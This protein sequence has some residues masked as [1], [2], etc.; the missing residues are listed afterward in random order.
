L[1]SSEP[2]SA[3]RFLPEATALE[4]CALPQLDPSARPTTVARVSST[5]LLVRLVVKREECPLHEPILTEAAELGTPDYPNALRV[6]LHGQRLHP[7][8]LPKRLATGTPG[9]A[10]REQD[11]LAEYAQWWN[12]GLQDGTGF[13]LAADKTTEDLL[14]ATGSAL[15]AEPSDPRIDQALSRWLDVYGETAFNLDPTA[16]IELVP[17]LAACLLLAQ[18]GERSDDRVAKACAVLLAHQAG[19]RAARSLHV[20]V[21]IRHWLPLARGGTQGQALPVHARLAQLQLHSEMARKQLRAALWVGHGVLAWV[22]DGSLDDGSAPI[23]CAVLAAVGELTPGLD[24]ARGS[25]LLAP[26]AGLGRALHPPN[27]DV[28][29][30]AELLTEQVADLKLLLR[31]ALELP[32]SL[33]PLTP[34]A[35]LNRRSWQLVRSLSL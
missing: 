31:R 22:R 1:T 29:A 17:M 11:R 26:L 34:H 2:P 10:A 12:E 7:V 27:G 5:A 13:V 14:R 23:A 28:V 35:V 16:E 19:L 18:R 25:E 6:V 9:P 21:I 8:D 20:E 32:V 15:T 30:Q 24:V 3:G 33:L 4:P